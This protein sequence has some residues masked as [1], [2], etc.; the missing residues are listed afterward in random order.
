MTE[1][2]IKVLRNLLKEEISDTKALTSI[3][4]NLIKQ[5]SDIKAKEAAKRECIWFEG[6]SNCAKAIE[7]LMGD[8]ATP[9]DFA[10]LLLAYIFSKSKVAKEHCTA[11]DAKKMRTILLRD[12]RELNSMIAFL[13]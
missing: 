12:L 5:V 11:E 1:N 4:N 7:N 10:D 3:C 9:D 8:C 2:N 6:T 13:I